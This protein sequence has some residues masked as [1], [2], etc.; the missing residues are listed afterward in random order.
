MRIQ[1]RASRIGL[2]AVC[3]VMALSF[4]CEKKPSQQPQPTPVP[5]M[6]PG[7]QPTQ[8]AVP[9]KGAVTPKPVVTG[10]K[11]TVPVPDPQV[12]DVADVALAVRV[13]RVDQVLPK[14]TSLCQAFVPT[15]TPEMI[16]D[17]I[18]LALADPALA[19][20]DQ[21]RSIMICLFAPQGSPAPG[22]AVLIPVNNDQYKTRFETMGSFVH[23]NPGGK[24]LIV[25]WD[26]A[27][28]VAARTALGQLEE[29]LNQPPKADL[30]VY[31]NVE[32]LMSRYNAA[33]EAGAKHMI[34][35]MMAQLQAVG[36]Q[37]PGGTDAASVF[38]LEVF[39]FLEF[40][41]EVKDLEFSVSLTKAGP[42]MSFLLRAKPGTAL[43]KALEYPYVADM[44]ALSFV[45]GTGAIVGCAGATDEAGIAWLGGVLDR[46]AAA[47]P[48][49]PNSKFDP[50]KMKDVWMMGMGRS[51]AAAFDVLSPTPGGGMSGLIV[52]KVQDPEKFMSVARNAQ[53]IIDAAGMSS[54]MPMNIQF[55]ENVRTYKGV[56]IHK[57]TQT[58]EMP[59][60]GMGMG[61]PETA[62]VSSMMQ[63]FLN[64]NAE[65]AV[66]GDY[67]VSA[68]GGSKI[69]PVIDA[70]LA[71]KPLSTG[72]VAAMSMVKEAD[73][74]M[75]IHPTRAISFVLGLLK[76]VGPQA[77]AM[78]P[79][80]AAAQ[81]EPITVTGS[82]GEGKAQ[83][84]A[85]IPLASVLQIRDL[86][87]QAMMGGPA[88]P[89]AP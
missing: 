8:A 3:A 41:K 71:K 50:K 56:A 43:A 55:Q 20:L 65:T 44:S 26:E 49:N 69:E 83:F 64:Q 85:A 54:F 39:G 77:N 11:K 9:T 5:G 29:L 33:I 21:S 88:A 87:M 62:I 60:P 75:D 28:A 17:R 10:P 35:G 18:A 48:V 47:V 36:D 89:V 53:E 6:T 7:A 51:Q 40:A 2:I 66:V 42:Q 12:I 15:F 67:V 57:C 58:G 61:G 63:T 4:A 46:A 70:I 37:M 1:Q 30:S 52:Y 13:N 34:Q 74:Y 68:M 24:T 82:S 86:V 19:G 78:A 72:K 27:A 73:L 23:Q 16:R 76:D 80:I 22:L 31:V 59:M 25:A 81:V 14:V 32:M 84:S 38:A 45:P 79:A